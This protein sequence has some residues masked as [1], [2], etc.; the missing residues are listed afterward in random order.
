MKHVKV[1]FF[2]TLRERAGTKSVEFEIE[3]ATTVQQ[4]KARLAAQFPNLETSLSS[5]LI[6]INREYAFPD[7]VVPQNA[8]VALF[9]PVSGG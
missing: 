9:P 5:A 6:S 7:A 3:D 1:L 2:A 8:E 4:L